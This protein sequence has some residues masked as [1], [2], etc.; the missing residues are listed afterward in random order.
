MG[1]SPV[2]SLNR[3]LGKAIHTYRMIE[4]GDR[5][6][7]GLSGG[8]DSLTLMWMLSDRLSRI[9]VRYELVAVYV[10]PGFPGGFAGDLARYARHQGY[11]VWVEFTDH[12]VRAHGPENRENPCFL[13]ARLRRKRL[14]EIADALGCNKLALG[15]HQDDFIETFFINVCYAGEI[16]TMRP[17]QSFFGG[18]LTVIRPLVFAG[19]RL[20]RRFARSAGFPNYDNPCPSSRTSRRSEIKSLLHTLYSGNP[21]IRGNVFRALGHVKPEYLLIPNPPQKP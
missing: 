20:I 18:K 13:C 9:P 5:I 3:C 7:V 15:H 17:H 11:A 1:A 16:S 6:A 21:K 4:D 2:R 14:F 12:G 8:K 10:D 19:E